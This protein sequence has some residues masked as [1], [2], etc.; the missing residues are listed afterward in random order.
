LPLVTWPRNQ[1]SMAFHD[2]AK[3]S[4]PS[5][6]SMN[7]CEGRAEAAGTY[8]QQPYRWGSTSA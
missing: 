2:A 7:T 5:C 1:R 4:T 8:S 3:T 6:G